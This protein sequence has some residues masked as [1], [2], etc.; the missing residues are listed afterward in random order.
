M[1]KKN[2]NW[3]FILLALGLL[4]Y[5]GTHDWFKGNF[6]IINQGNEG[7]SSN[8]GETLNPPNSAPNP[9]CTDSDGGKIF[10]IGGKVT[11]S[12]GNMYDTCQ[13]NGMDLL[14]FYCENGVQKSAGIGCIN[15]CVDSAS[16]D[17]CSPTKIWHSG[18]TV[19]SGTGT[20]SLIGTNNLGSIDLAEYG[21]TTDGN[22]QLGAQI[23]TSWDYDN[24]AFCQGVWGVE[25]IKLDFYDSN[26]LEYS[27]TDATPV[28]L[29]IDLHPTDHYLE[30]NGVT[31]WRGEISMFPQ[32][33]PNC[34]I[35]Y[36]YSVRIY[37]Y[38]CN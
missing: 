30:W 34:V 9:T 15:G 5:G 12:L 36:E 32:V 13:P 16:G 11:T 19:F 35:N 17:Y 26:G 8:G 27:R 33:L 2:Y 14:E 24:P 10:N 21:I 25:G 28:A 20:G 6:S 18:D 4:Y 3:I 23:Q 31:P 1:A 7:S 29:G 37:I 22:C 38:S